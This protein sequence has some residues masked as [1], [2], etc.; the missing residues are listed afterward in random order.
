MTSI[1]W[2]GRLSGGVYNNKKSQKIHILDGS[3]FTE[4]MAMAGV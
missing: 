4:I 3:R 2:G 1:I